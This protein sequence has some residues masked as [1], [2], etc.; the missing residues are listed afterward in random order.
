MKISPYEEK[1]DLTNKF[2]EVNSPSEMFVRPP[3]LAEETG[4][5][6]NFISGTIK[7]LVVW[8][9]SHYKQKPTDKQYIVGEKYL[10]CPLDEAYFHTQLSK[11]P[12]GFIFYLEATEAKIEGVDAEMNLHLKSQP[13]YITSKI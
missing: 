3:N 1:L 10:L 8:A 2:V 11:S 9:K 13:I 12:T 5:S 7:E 4:G 6:N